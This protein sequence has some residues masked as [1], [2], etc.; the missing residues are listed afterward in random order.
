MDTE[1]ASKQGEV[2]TALDHLNNSVSR[3]TS[4]VDI[5]LPM[6]DSVSRST[7]PHAT[8]DKTERESVCPISDEIFRLSREVSN[9]ITILEEKE[10][11]LEL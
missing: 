2:R 10:G 1:V 5:L 6:L 7:P 8:T 4:C 3:L 9:V 11:L